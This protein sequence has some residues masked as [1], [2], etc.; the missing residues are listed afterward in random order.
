MKVAI[1]VPDSIFHEAEVLA[2]A[3]N[4]SRSQLYAEALAGFVRSHGA[5]NITERINAVC[6]RE[7]TALE[8]AFAAAQF[9]ALT[10]ETW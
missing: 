9:T 7:S 1:S 5:H 6:A 4:K 2:S 8:P 3:L 10:R